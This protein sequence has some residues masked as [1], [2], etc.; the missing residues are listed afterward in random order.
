MRV[1]I[2]IMTATTAA[3]TTAVFFMKRHA[4]KGRYAACALIAAVILCT[5]PITAYA[6]GDDPEQDIDLGEILIPVVTPE[7]TSEPTP[8]PE[9][10]PLT[11]PGNLTLVDDLSG[12]QS[13]DKQF[14]T[15]ITKNGNYFYIVIDRA[16]ENQNVHF[17]NLV[18]EADLLALME[19]EARPQV[20]TPAPIEPTPAEP[21][22]EP[23][24]EPKSNNMGGILIV[25]LLVGAIGGGAYYYLKVL[26]P[27]Q[28]TKKAAVTELDEFAFDEDEE[29]F[30]GAAYYEPDGSRL[31]EGAAYED[32]M[33]DDPT[34]P[35][36]DGEF[37]FDLGDFDTPES[38]DK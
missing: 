30:D 36:N 11:P 10:R 15:V 20:T 34:E 31:P 1:I 23:D 32:D 7:P 9:L 38:E 14:I 27:K 26:K 12:E 18:D 17:L 5:L 35:D 33:T 4:K 16:G 13:E 22:P 25:L 29:D 6:G 21:T 2:A 28:G 19:D 37:T 24:P 3:A 8:T